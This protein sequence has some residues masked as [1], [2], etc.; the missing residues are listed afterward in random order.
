MPRKKLK[1]DEVELWEQVAKSATPLRLSQYVNSV[2][3]PKPKVNPK[4]KERFELNNF[5]IGAN[6]TQKSVKNDLKPSISSAL[7]NAP[8]QMDYKSFKKMKQGKS[9]PEATFDLH[10][11]TVAQAHAALIHFL[12]ASYSRNMRLV[13]VI[14]GKGKIQKDTGPI[15]RQVGILRHQ[16]PQWLRMPPLRDKVLQVSEAHGKHGGSGAYYVYLR[17]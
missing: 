17:K 13:L 1:P 8:V 4:K 7:E 6:A 12:M 14:T 16:V 2:V 9:T 15:P 10:G 3:K 11:M 5:E